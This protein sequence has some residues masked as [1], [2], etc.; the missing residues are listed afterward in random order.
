[1]VIELVSPIRFFVAES[2]SSGHTVC[3]E[4]STEA[5]R[6]WIAQMCGGGSEPCLAATV[7]VP[8]RTVAPACPKDCLSMFDVA[9]IVGC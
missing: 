1:M 7:S 4:E 8:E 3:V 5:S 2:T 6:A 9:M